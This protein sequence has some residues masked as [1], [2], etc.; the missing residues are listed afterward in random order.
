MRFKY[1]L[2]RTK[3]FFGKLIPSTDFL[4]AYFAR[5]YCR[6]DSGFAPDCPSFGVRWR[7]LSFHY[8]FRFG[9][10]KRAKRFGRKA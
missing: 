1:A 7:Q 8:A 5:P 6:Q 10:G 3:Y 9:S 4:T 2:P